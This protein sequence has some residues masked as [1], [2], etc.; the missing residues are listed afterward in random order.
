MKKMVIEN[1]LLVSNRNNMIK[2]ILSMGLYLLAGSNIV[3]A[4]EPGE[5]AL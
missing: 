2:Q 3:L 5:I 1:Y 4:H